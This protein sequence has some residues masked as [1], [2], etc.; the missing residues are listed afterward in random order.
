MH[1]HYCACQAAVFTR[2]YDLMPAFTQAAS[3]RFNPHAGLAAAA[4]LE[5]A[6]LLS[7]E[8]AGPRDY[9]IRRDPQL[10]RNH[11]LAGLERA[12]TTLDNH[13]RGEL[14]E[15]FVLLADREN[16]AAETTVAI[17]D[18]AWTLCRLAELLEMS[19]R[20]AAMRLLL[21]YLDDPTRPL[22]ALRS[23]GGEAT[24]RSCGN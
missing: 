21:S 15:A 22:A 17:A 3:D 16:A 14:L 1:S 9:R 4:T 24:S 8:L 20:P 5:L 7:D 10:Q 23:S 19:S 13:R 2:D 18:R 11:V 6:E 12:V